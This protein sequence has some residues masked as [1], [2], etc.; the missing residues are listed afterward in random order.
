M[1][2]IGYSVRQGCHLSARLF[3]FNIDN[4][5]TNIFEKREVISVGGWNINCIRYANEIVI[6]ND[7]YKALERNIKKQKDDTKLYRMKSNTT[8]S[9][10]GKNKSYENY[11][12]RK[13]Q[14]QQTKGKYKLKYLIENYT[15]GGLE[16]R[17]LI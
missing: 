12:T 14:S 6:L 13:W 15:N 11:K 1:N 4:M 16:V 17:R 5:L 7:D 10:C 3:N 2:R 8:C 9:Q